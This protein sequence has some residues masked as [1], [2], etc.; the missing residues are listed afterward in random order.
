[1][2]FALRSYW[3]AGAP[4]RVRIGLNLKGVAYDYVGVDLLAGEQ[5]EPAFQAINPQRLVPVLE[6]DG[7]LLIQSLAI[8]EWLEETHPEP[9]LLPRAA[10]SRSAVPPV[11][12]CRRSHRC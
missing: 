3:R 12:S 8:L 4:Y 2:T 7:A 10:A 5:L 11:C 1:M 9:P 6:A